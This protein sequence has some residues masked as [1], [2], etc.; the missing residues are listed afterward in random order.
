M[1]PFPVQFTGMPSRKTGAKRSPAADILW[2]TAR[3][4]P[5]Y[6]SLC[7]LV[8]RRRADEAIAM[9]FDPNDSSNDYLW[10]PPGS[11]LLVPT[12]KELLEKERNDVLNGYRDI[13]RIFNAAARGNFSSRRDDPNR[14]LDPSDYGVREYDRESRKAARWIISC[15][16]EFT[17]TP[18]PLTRIEF[19][20]NGALRVDL[21]SDRLPRAL[22]KA[23]VPAGTYDTCREMNLQTSYPSAS[24]GQYL[25]ERAFELMAGIPKPPLGA[26]GWHDV[27]GFL[28]GVILR[29]H[30][31][32]DGNGRTARM[33]YAVALFQGGLPF[34]APTKAT[35]DEMC[36]L[37][38]RT[39]GHR[40][41]EQ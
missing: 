32:T 20:I 30:S 15:S 34:V 13:C 28:L 27:A 10:V 41:G 14:F 7:H 1:N 39:F 22:H 12:L 2:G 6:Q 36:L 35:E 4:L 21:W 33:A 3:K 16:G 24:G 38:P 5:E 9:T 26:T 40:G 31:L 11:R 8:G 25:I 17:K 37:P 23:C 18:V 19:A 29:A